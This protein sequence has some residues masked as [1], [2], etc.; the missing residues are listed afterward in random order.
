METSVNKRILGQLSYL[1]FFSAGVLASEIILTRIFSVVF[2]YHFGFL[3]LSTAMLGFGIGGFLVRY[4]S[5]KLK[6][7]PYNALLSTSSIVSGVTLILALLIIT[8]NPFH[9]SDPKTSPNTIALCM[10]LEI[11]STSFMLI[12][13]FTIMGAVTL[14]MLQREKENVGPLYASNLAGSAMGCLVA[15]V[16]MNMGGGVKA[17][18]LVSSLLVLSGSIPSWP[19]T[20]RMAVLCVIIALLIPGS[21]FL[22]DFLFPIKSPQG[23]PATT[24]EPSQRVM[25]DWTSLARVDIYKEKNWQTNEFGLWGLSSANRSLLPERLGVLIDYWAYTTILKHSNSP[26]YYDFLENLPMYGMYRITPP[27]PNMMIIGSGGGM[28]IRAGLHFGASHINAVEINPSIFKVMIDDF[29]EYSGNVYRDPKVTAYLGEGR[30]ILSTSDASYDIIQ[31]S[32]VDTFSATQ[33]GAF[34]LTENYLYTMEAFGTYLDHLKPQGLL[35]LTH[36]YL[37]STTGYPRF[38]LRLF[39]LAYSALKAQGIS[40]PDK[41]MFFFHSKRFAVLLVKKIP[42]SLPEIQ[43]LSNLGTEKQYTCLFRPD[44]VIF[45]SMHFYSFVKSPDKQTWFNDYPFNVTPPTDDSPFYFENRKFGTIFNP[46]NYIAGYTR[47]DGQTILAVLFIEMLVAASALVIGSFRMEKKNSDIKGWLYFFCIGLGFM[48][49]E[50]SFAQQLVLF[51]G[52]P[53]YALSVVLFSILLFSG[54]GSY[55]AKALAKQLPIPI[56]LLVV[57]LIFAV[58]AFFGIPLIRGLSGMEPLLIRI[59]VAVLFLGPVSFLMGTAFP[60]AV[61]RLC[62]SGKTESLGIYWAFNSFASVIGAVLAIILAIASGFT[63]VMLAACF[64]YFLA[65]LF[66][67]K[68]SA[69]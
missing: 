35:S 3:V 44:Q 38:S 60:E 69:T 49:A 2:W 32:G 34:A 53:V 65:A 64:C 21:L 30:N 40:E 9:I 42:F 22:S 28:D 66:F 7:Y 52:H 25:S 48:L 46:G 61:T 41:H 63:V 31:L 58:Q 4:H 18:V 24:I 29:A 54:I 67:P 57:S 19:T 50:V 62:T 36:W 43:T 59:S 13:P 10:G 16:L 12:V 14:F 20:K 11:L 15:I 5:D 33:A 68:Y 55:Y 23:K 45:S 1:G 39:C 47:F 37:P 27:K 8:N 56:I 26:G 6:N 17:L 51:L